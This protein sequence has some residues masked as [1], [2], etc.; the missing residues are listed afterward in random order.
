MITCTCG[1]KKK[2]PNSETESRKAGGKEKGEMFL[3]V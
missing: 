2:K 3:K 1:I